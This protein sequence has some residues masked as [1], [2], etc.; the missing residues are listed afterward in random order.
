MARKCQVCGSRKWRKD[1][2]TG[3]A[4]CEEGHVLQDFRSENHVV[5]GIPTH[6][7]TKRRLVKGPRQNKR[8]EE[9][10]ANP[11][12]YH[13]DEAEYL[14]LQGL[15]ILLRLQ[16]QA[17]SKLWALPDAFEMVIRD[18]WAYQLA[19][20]SLPSPPDSSSA[21]TEILSPDAKTMPEVLGKA[22][23]VG[24][25][26]QS[27]EGSSADEEGFEDEDGQD[28]KSDSELD[29]EVLEK[30]TESDKE[31]QNFM[32]NSPNGQRRDTSWKRRRRLRVSDTVST[33]VI[34]LWVLRIPVMYVDMENLINEVKI[35]YIDFAHTTYLSDEMKKHMNRDVTAAL[36]P[37]RSP[38]PLTMHRT[39]KLFARALRRRYGIAVPEVNVHP[40][41]WRVLSVLGGTPTTYTQTLRLLAL[42]DVNLSLLERE[43]ATFS[44][45]VR[46]K[47][48]MN[49][50]G[51]DSE[52]DQPLKERKET[53]ER[54]RQYQDIPPPEVAVVT[55]WVIIMK[56]AYGLDG[57]SRN[58]LL[59][60]DPLIDMPE[61]TAWVTELRSRVNNGLLKAGRT[62]LDKQDF[63][64]MDEE[65]IDIY[66]T[67]CEAVLLDHRPEIPD[68]VPFPLPP[69]VG[70]PPPLIP[71]NTWH[72]YHTNVKTVQHSP[73]R[74]D[75]TN[76]TL[77]LMP[78]EKIL[79]YDST[80][81]T[82]ELDDSVE[83]VL[84]AASE[85]VGCDMRELM[86]I[87]EVF[88][89]KLEK[90]RITK[91]DEEEGWKDSRGRSSRLGL[92]RE[93]SG[94]GTRSG[95]IS[96]EVSRSRSG[97]MARRSTLRGS[98]SF[99]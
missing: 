12:F 5:D 52:S 15:Q 40:I 32:E 48:T 94:S 38:A 90:I 51:S 43:I 82:G 17:L 95:A 83:V 30:L 3:N 88:E 64:S 99:G 18:L 8:K 87:V 54:T 24:M 67:K 77:P 92:R 44:R 19:M 4:V 28:E 26:H 68:A 2:V 11:E 55:A 72:S 78:G 73:L 34:G 39:C 81:L 74:Q 20:S 16:A 53:Y 96:R 46:S 42:L 84:R 7:L 70:I 13:R 62:T 89:R 49:D 33:L 31:E 93:N 75:K 45:R 85:V 27:D 61:S 91:G 98:R 10:R 29:P 1:G 35:P 9:G 22:S 97:S 71:P 60:S 36:S 79:S 69:S 57:L 23:D 86:S 47:T 14:R 66:L 37:L 56:M 80:D 6:A 21:S 76:K 65:D 50:Q 25:G 41:A 63:V 58:A 59:Q